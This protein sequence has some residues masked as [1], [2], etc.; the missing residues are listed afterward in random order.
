MKSTHHTSFDEHEVIHELK[1]YLPAQAPLK[2][3]I[4]HNTLHAF[5]QMKFKDGV[6]HASEI[7]GYR[8]SLSLSDFRNR[9]EKGQII[10]EILDRVILQKK[11]ADHLVEWRKKVLTQ[12][13]ENVALPRIGAL[14]ANWKKH[15]RI[16]LDSLVQPTLFRILCSYLDQGIAIWNFPV[17]EKTFLAA[18]REMERNT[19]ASFFKGNRARKLLFLSLIHI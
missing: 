4:H 8:S 7:L 13:Y 9:Y 17:R 11:G 6:R 19:L 1:H 2:D 18:I 5:Q 16:D 12:P 3:F 15:Y 10:S 14:R